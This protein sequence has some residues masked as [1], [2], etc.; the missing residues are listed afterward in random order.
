MKYIYQNGK[1][2]EKFRPYSTP[3]DKWMRYLCDVR[4]DKEKV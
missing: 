2:K 3:M 4:L 1:G